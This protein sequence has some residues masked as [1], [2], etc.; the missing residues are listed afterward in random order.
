MSAASVYAA[1]PGAVRTAKTG[2]YLERGRATTMHMQTTRR[3]PHAMTLLAT[4]VLL[5][6][7]GLA[8]AADGTP[9]TPATG[10]AQDA[11]PQS[12]Q[13]AQALPEPQMAAPASFVLRSVAFDGATGVA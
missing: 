5:A 4:A 2:T 3:V 13:Q 7:A 6:C 11:P 9:A 10:A 8:Q 12:G 1:T